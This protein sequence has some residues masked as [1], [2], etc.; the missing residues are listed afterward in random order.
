MSLISEG[1]CIFC[2]LVNFLFFCLYGL[3]SDENHLQKCRKKE[4]DKYKTGEPMIYMHNTQSKKNTCNQHRPCLYLYKVNIYIYNIQSWKL[5]HYAFK[6][7]QDK[8]GNST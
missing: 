7:Y 4:C 5:G 6:E 3:F 2:M 1:T 8:Y